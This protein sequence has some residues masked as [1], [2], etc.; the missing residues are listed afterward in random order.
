MRCFMWQDNMVVMSRFVREAMRMVSAVSLGDELDIQF[1]KLAGTDRCC[2][3]LILHH[4]V[5]SPFI[6]DVS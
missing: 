2:Y 1:A 3:F 6:S 5:F 4:E